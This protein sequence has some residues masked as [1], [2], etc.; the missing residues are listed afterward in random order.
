MAPSKYPGDVDDAAFSKM[1]ESVRK[2]V[3]CFFGILKGRFRILKLR[4][5]YH[6]R[7]DIDNIFFTC[8][9]LHNMLHSFD[10][11]SVFKENVDWAGSAGL[12]DPKDHAPDTDFTS[13]GPRPATD[14]EEYL[15]NPQH[16]KL[17]GQLIESF[18]YR[19]KNNDVVWLSRPK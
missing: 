8:C 12:H 3:E 14:P 16:A 15:F 5:A 2:D 19:K 6:C 18:A 9:I 13:V 1:L 7:E 4:L 17:K 11:M 10:G